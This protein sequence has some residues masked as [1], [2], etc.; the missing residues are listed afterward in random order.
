MTRM[1]GAAQYV[2]RPLTS[3]DLAVVRELHATL[4][5]MRYPSSFFM[6]LL[7]QK[8]R[9]CLVACPKRDPSD[10]VAFVSAA[11]HEGCRYSSCEFSAQRVGPRADRARSTEPHVEI[12]TLGVLREHQHHGLAQQLVHAAASALLPRSKHVADSDSDTDDDA[13]AASS[14]VLIQA[15]VSAVNDSARRFYERL[16]L[17]TRERIANAYRVST[18]SGCR[19]AYLVAGRINCAA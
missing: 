14:G 6:S 1:N 11:K 9:V 17:R 2:V 13:D 12:L 3:A 5:P 4:L 7:L 19:D 15:H 8:D 18:I 16:G 10:V